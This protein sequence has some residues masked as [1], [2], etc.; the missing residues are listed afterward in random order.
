[1]SEAVSGRLGKFGEIGGNRLGLF[2]SKKSAC[3][4]TP[5]GGRRREILHWLGCFG[6]FFAP[7][8]CRPLYAGAAAAA[9][10]DWRAAIRPKEPFAQKRGSPV[11]DFSSVEPHPCVRRLT[12]PSSLLRRGP[13]LQPPMAHARG[14]RALRAATELVRMRGSSMQ[15]DAGPDLHMSTC[16]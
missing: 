14:G 11:F 2:G 1:M 3:G 4:G 8:R 13:Q 7:T 15:V 5:D 6:S 16:T 9:A 10:Y 12:Q